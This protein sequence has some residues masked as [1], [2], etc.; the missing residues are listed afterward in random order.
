[1]DKKI[2]IGHIS[3][4][5]PSRSGLYEASRDMCR[6]DILG[7]NE[8]YFFDAGVP[9]KDSRAEIKVGA[10]D[11]RA[12]FKLITSSPDLIQDM[13]ILI[14]HT[15]IDDKYVV[16]SQS[17]IIWVVHGKPLD[18]YRPEMNG[19]RNSYTLY[20]ELS[21][22]PKSKYM[23]YFWPEY[24]PYWACFPEQKHL[25]FD[26][27]VIDEERF[28]NTGEIYKIT[29]K[30]KYNILVCDSDRADTDKFELI[31]SAIEI[32]KKIKG[33]KFHFAGLDMPFKTCER[34]LLDK[35]QEVGGLGD[36]IK[37]TDN[38]QAVYKSMDLTFS[39]NRII[40]RVIAESLCCGTPVLTE[41]GCKVADYTTYVPDVNKV[42]DS[43]TKFINDFDNKLIDKQKIIE[44]S[45]VFNMKNYYTQINKVY[46]EVLA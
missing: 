17:P 38:M 43:I 5:A 2:K 14:M 40:N 13:D 9:E 41:I 25:I 30:G 42:I 44:R 23:L 28:N 6:A 15:G 21:K 39:P 11:N 45:K 35:L 18:C 34:A 37:R 8:A 1:L 3:F 7:G 19:Q 33:I 12:G 26:Y 22:W 29:D 27:P 4:F 24:K 20:N 16:K 32:S 36:I 46:K 31:I 10:E